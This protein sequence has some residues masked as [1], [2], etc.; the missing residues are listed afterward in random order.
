MSV[1]FNFWLKKL[2]NKDLKFYLKLIKEYK[3]QGFIYNIGG[4]ITQINKILHYDFEDIRMNPNETK[5]FFKQNGWDKD[6]IIGFQTRNPMHCSHVNLTKYALEQIP[7]SKL[8]LNPV[9]GITQNCDIDYY[10]LNCPPLSSHKTLH[11]TDVILL[12]CAGKS[13]IGD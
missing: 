10:T 13:L 9:V 4:K 3:K 1:S 12:T 5:E 6:P 8:F 2:N 7:K 11:T